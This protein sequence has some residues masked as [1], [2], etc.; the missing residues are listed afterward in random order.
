M[1]YIRNNLLEFRDPHGT[2]IPDFGV[3]EFAHHPS[4]SDRDGRTWQQPKLPSGT[5][6]FLASPGCKSTRR[7]K[8]KTYNYFLKNLNSP[9]DIYVHIKLN[10]N[11]Y[12]YLC[13]SVGK[14]KHS[15]TP[16]TPT[17]TILRGSLKHGFSTQRRCFH[18]NP[19]FFNKTVISCLGMSPQFSIILFPKIQIQLH[20]NQMFFINILIINCI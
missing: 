12:L 5:S 20:T 14:K 9:Y 13:V 8:Q 18:Q 11:I 3:L 19:G 7:R 10:Y 17:L 16:N 2:R 1:D 6:E 4:W 15:R